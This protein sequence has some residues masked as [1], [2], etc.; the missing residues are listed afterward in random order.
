MRPSSHLI[1]FYLFLPFSLEPLL[2]LYLWW[3]Y[4]PYNSH[5]RH[6][7]NL[8]IPCLF[9]ISQS[10]SIFSPHYPTQFTSITHSKVEDNL[11]SWGRGSCIH[12]VDNINFFQFFQTYSPFSQNSFKNNRKDSPNT[13]ADYRFH[14]DNL[15]FILI[16]GFAFDRALKRTSTGVQIQ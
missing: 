15:K 2:P 16:G 9:L 14:L 4:K 11:L 13:L 6:S 12:I 8:H 1:I 5:P 3:T 10:L 7:F